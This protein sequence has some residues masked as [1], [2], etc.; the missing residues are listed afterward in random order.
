MTHF[1][2]LGVDGIRATRE[3]DDAN[4]V[5]DTVKDRGGKTSFKTMGKS[6]RKKVSFQDMEHEVSKAPS[7]KTTEETNIKSI[8]F[9]TFD[10]WIKART[11]N[12]DLALKD[13]LS[14]ISDK[15]SAVD[16]EKDS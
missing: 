15:K 11:A 3:K 7:I 2:T 4:R 16:G 10:K 5:K 9:K 8:S 14:F 13:V 6:E 1:K 12:C